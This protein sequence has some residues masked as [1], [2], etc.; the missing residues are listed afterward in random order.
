M[1]S[2]IS[3]QAATRAVLAPS[4]SLSSLLDRC[5]SE[6]FSIDNYSFSSSSDYSKA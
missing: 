6:K 2:S 4:K 3:L 1:N 5:Q